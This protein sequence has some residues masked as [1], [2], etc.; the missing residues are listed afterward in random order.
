MMLQELICRGLFWK[1]GTQMSLDF[2]TK[3]MSSTLIQKIT[4]KLYFTFGLAFVP[5]SRYSFQIQYTT[6]VFFQVLLKMQYAHFGNCGIV[7]FM[8]LNLFFVHNVFFSIDT[9]KFQQSMFSQISRYYEDQ[10]QCVGSDGISID[11]LLYFSR[12]PFL[13]LVVMLLC[14]G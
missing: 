4:K 14:F 2:I 8:V 5:S 13:V 9:K 3:T 1:D 10:K 7:F 11:A 6:I 12:T